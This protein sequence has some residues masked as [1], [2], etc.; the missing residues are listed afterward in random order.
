MTRTRK[1]PAWLGARAILTL[2]ITAAVSIA[3]ARHADACSR[4]FWNDNGVTMISGRTMDWEHQFND[5]LWIM[6]KGIKRSGRAGDNSASWTSKFGSVV[7]VSANTTTDGLNEAG[8]A[9]HLL[10]LDTG[11]YEP[12]DNRPGVGTSTWLQYLLDNF[13]NVDEALAHPK[14]VQIVNV[15]S[16]G[17]EKGLPLHVA[18]EDVS[19]NS[20]VVEFVD[21]R[22]V[23]HAGR[24][25]QVMTN[26]PRYDEQLANLRRYLPFGG[27]TRLPGNIYPMDR[28]VRAAYFL[29]YL[30]KPKDPEEAAAYMMS[31]VYN[32]SV[33]FGA[34]YVGVSG[35]YPTWWRDVI[36][37]S[38][39]RIYFDSALSP[40]VIWVNFDSL[41]FEKGQPSKR[42]DVLD[43]AL[44]GDVSKK[45][46]PAAAPY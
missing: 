1:I 23:V 6:P 16:A 4:I 32:V 42:L 30:P 40:N 45:F 34:P 46:A 37:L 33:P 44:V 36:D 20:A 13:K 19:G 21:G 28:F 11:K 9:A 24:Q 17:Y 18:M 27:D 39:R 35:T 14:D 22:M 15:G 8:L 12:R 31:L 41:N 2:A 38:N 7:V 10:Y 43:P 5:V 29:H 25:Y 26:E 3:L